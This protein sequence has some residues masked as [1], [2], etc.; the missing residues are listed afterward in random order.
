MLPTHSPKSRSQGGFS[1]VELILTITIIGVIAGI[2]VPIIQN[3]FQRG[4]EA[5]ARRNAQA[6]AG[7]A[8]SAVAAG[9]TAI[10]DASD[11]AAAVALLTTGVKGEGQFAENIF[12]IHLEEEERA[13]SLKYLEFKDGELAFDPD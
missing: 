3:V 13:K 9:S 4:V 12:V 11:K 5:S 8:S 1:L 7:V 6:I 10:N 2:A